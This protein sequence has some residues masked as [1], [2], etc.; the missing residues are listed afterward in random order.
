MEKKRVLEENPHLKKLYLALVP[1]KILTADEFWKEIAGQYKQTLA[2]KMD[3]GVS[4][5]FLVS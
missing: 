3:V 2:P 5:A 4:A 1:T